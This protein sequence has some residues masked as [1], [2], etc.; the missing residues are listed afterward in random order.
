MN[1]NYKIGQISKMLKISTRAIR[2][3]EEKGLITPCIKD[4][5]NGYRYFNDKQIFILKKIIFLKDLGL[6]LEQIKEYLNSDILV[7]Q[8]LLTNHYKKNSQLNEILKK[9]I[10][11][12][13]Y[14]LSFLENKHYFG[15]NVVSKNLDNIV[16]TWVLSGIYQNIK[17]ARFNKNKINLFTPY[18]F[19]SFNHDGQSPWFYYATEKKIIFNTFFLSVA[20]IYQIEDN[21]LYLMISNPKDHLFINDKNNITFSH[22]LVFD[23]YSNNF[24]D[25]KKFLTMDS[26]PTSFVKDSEIVGVYKLIGIC[27]NFL[28]ENYKENV[29]NNGYNL[30]LIYQNGRIEEF[31][32]N[33]VKIKN[34]TKNFIYDSELKIVYHYKINNDTLIFENKTN[35]YRFTGKF[36]NYLVYKKLF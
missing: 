19:L 18:Q 35:I 8:K 13:L 20:E 34:W 3:Y 4:N 5:I 32:N 11:N 26:L 9:I 17:D 24:E 23:K 25:Y 22:I 30:M 2:F 10:D 29:D 12:K 14:D 21:K 16:G 1:E 36:N 27:D 15:Y 7:K 33:K 6:S 31:S 28:K